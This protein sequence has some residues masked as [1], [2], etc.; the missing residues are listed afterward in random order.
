MFPMKLFC[1]LVGY[2]VAP[3]THYRPL[4]GSRALKEYEK[5][6]LHKRFNFLLPLVNFPFTK[7]LFESRPRHCQYRQNLRKAEQIRYVHCKPKFLTILI[8]RKRKKRKSSLLNS[9]VLKGRDIGTFSLC[10]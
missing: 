1:H 8:S 7:L 10:L 2:F 6:K 3:N 9:V 5:L 4:H